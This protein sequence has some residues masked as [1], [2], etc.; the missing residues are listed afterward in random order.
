MRRNQLIARDLARLDK[1]DALGFL[2][3]T[4]QQSIAIAGKTRLRV[5]A[6]RVE[7][8]IEEFQHG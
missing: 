2:E 7:R 5:D 4:G 6:V 3:P 1:L 8:V